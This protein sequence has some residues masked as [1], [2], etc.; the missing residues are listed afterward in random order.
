MTDTNPLRRKYVKKEVKR[1]KKL[2]EYERERQMKALYRKVSDEIDSTCARIDNDQ[3][4]MGEKRKEVRRLL[5]C[6]LVLPK[7]YRRTTF[8]KWK[9][10]SGK[11]LL[12]KYTD[13]VNNIVKTKTAHVSGLPLPEQAEVDVWWQDDKLIFASTATEFSLPVERVMGMGTTK[14]ISAYAVS[15]DKTYL[16]IEYIK[17][18]KIKCIV[19]RAT[20]KLQVS[21]L[22]EYFDQIKGT[23]E[24]IKQEL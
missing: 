21:H 10:F 8:K 2:P 1:I 11:V 23:K 15:G 14:E 4:S 7:E 24:R 13:E 9:N 6:V 5:Y 22:I 17:E 3:H 19:V 12:P 20:W 18:D 16:T